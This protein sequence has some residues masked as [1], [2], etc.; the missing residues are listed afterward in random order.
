MSKILNTNGAGST[1][2]IDYCKGSYPRAEDSGRQS[3]SEMKV[4]LVSLSTRPSKMS[5]GD[6]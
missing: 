3:C 6:Q 2:D 5:S 4:K 1:K